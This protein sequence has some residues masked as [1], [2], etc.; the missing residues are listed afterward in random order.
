MDLRTLF[1]GVIAS[2]TVAQAV[3][4]QRFAGV[5]KTAGC[6]GS[7]WSKE[8]GG[9]GG[10][11]GTTKR[12]KQRHPRGQKS[13]QKRKK[14]FEPGPRARRR[15]LWAPKRVQNG[16]WGAQGSGGKK[17]SFSQNPCF[18]GFGQNDPLSRADFCGKMAQ[19]GPL[20]PPTPLDPPRPP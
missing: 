18:P 11:R 20:D 10:A 4:P 5:V 9:V 16:P 1:G 19:N 14:W 15:A 3:T 17:G 13:V 2:A 8:G 7:S 12:V 6:V